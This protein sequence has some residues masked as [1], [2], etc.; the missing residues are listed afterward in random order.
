[1]SE[2][3]RTFSEEQF[4]F[5]EEKLFELFMNETYGEPVSPD[6]GF[7]V[8]KSRLNITVEMW[9]Q[10]IRD[11]LLFKFELLEDTRFPEWWLVPLLRKF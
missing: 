2:L 5:S 4:D 11:G 1:M 8:G 10:D 6:N 7:Y 9:R 3:Y